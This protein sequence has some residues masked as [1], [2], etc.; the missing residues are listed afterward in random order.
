MDSL[1]TEAVTHLSYGSEPP[2]VFELTDDLLDPPAVL[3]F[4]FGWGIRP[5]GSTP[6]KP[7]VKSR[8]S[9]GVTDMTLAPIIDMCS[10]TGEL[11]RGRCSDR[12]GRR[13]ERSRVAQS[14]CYERV[15]GLRR[16]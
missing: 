13:A 8:S 4:A 14:Q 7:P 11:A 9:V 1:M 6:S 12:Q 15:T 3:R 5:T 10:G 16:G 2:P